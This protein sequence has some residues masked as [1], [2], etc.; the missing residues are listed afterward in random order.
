MCLIL[1]IANQTAWDSG[2]MQSKIFTLDKD[3]GINLTTHN[4]FP[5]GHVCGCWFC[6]LIPPRTFFSLRQ[7]PF[8]YW[9][10]HKLLWLP[11]SLGKQIT[12]QN[13]TQH[14]QRPSGIFYPYIV[15]LQ[16]FTLT[17]WSRFPY[18]HHVVLPRCLPF[19]QLQYR[20]TMLHVLY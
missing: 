4:K 14:Y 18:H 19:Q 10:H 17:V 16:T 5:V 13:S 6:R 15:F 3:S 9:L 1:H 8:S 2:E 12:E 7:C 11:Y 20:K